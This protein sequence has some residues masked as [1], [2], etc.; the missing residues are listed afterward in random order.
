MARIIDF[1]A[2]GGLTW[3][4][5]ANFTETDAQVP[6]QAYDGVDTYVI[7]CGT[8]ATGNDGLFKSENDGVSFAR[9]TGITGLDWPND[10]FI[11]MEYGLSKLWLAADVSFGEGGELFSSTDDGSSWTLELKPAGS[12]FI[13]FAISGSG[14]MYASTDGSST[15]GAFDADG[16][17]LAD[18]S[19]DFFGQGASWSPFDNGGDGGESTYLFADPNS[20]KP[21]R[22][23]A[24]FYNFTADEARIIYSDD[25]GTTWDIARLGLTTEGFPMT[26]TGGCQFLWDGTNYHFLAGGTGGSYWFWSRD[27][28]VWTEAPAGAG[29]NPEIINWVADKPFFHVAAAIKDA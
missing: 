1:S 17:S 3:Q 11:K 29:N 2:D 21:N 20:A 26:V 13:T 24:A 6:L 22:F 15:N 5:V 19:A 25:N 7:F 12:L 4:R 14:I 28:S 18:F 10:R 9:V 8:T 23:F 16:V 27:G